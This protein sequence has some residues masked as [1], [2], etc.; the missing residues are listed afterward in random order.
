M[1]VQVILLLNKNQDMVK[2]LFAMSSKAQL[3]LERNR[4]HV[5]GNGA[6][7]LNK[8]FITRSR[9]DGLLMHSNKCFFELQSFFI[10]LP[11]HTYFLVA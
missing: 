3:C 9:E 2:K 5:E 6:K 1:L 4:V 10:Q 11:S 8:L 7:K